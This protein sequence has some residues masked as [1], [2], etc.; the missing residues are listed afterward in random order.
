MIAMDIMYLVT[1]LY[2]LF[3]INKETGNENHM[4]AA[5]VAPLFLSFLLFISMISLVAILE[6]GIKDIN[7]NSETGIEHSH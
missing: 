3:M 7:K 5:I 6:A 1:V 2:L 4:K